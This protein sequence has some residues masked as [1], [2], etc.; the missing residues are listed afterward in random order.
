M[1]HHF[2][3][4]SSKVKEKCPLKEH[5][6]LDQK[7]KKY[8]LIFCLCLHSEFSSVDK[9]QGVIFV[10]L[11]MRK[12]D[13]LMDS[14]GRR[15]DSCMEL[16]NNLCFIHPSIHFFI[17]PTFLAFLPCAGQRCTAGYQ[18][19]MIPALTELIICWTEEVERFSCVIPIY[20]FLKQTFM[21]EVERTETGLCWLRW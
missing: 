20:L 6:Q 5:P 19:K 2:E 10:L 4:E 16:E 14:Q 3:I 8:L 12:R 15:V 11:R 1:F 13:F 17:H 9:R 7:Y 21:L 18:S